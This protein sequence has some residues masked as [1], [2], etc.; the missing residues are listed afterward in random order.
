MFV[1]VLATLF[2][3]THGQPA[4][5]WADQPEKDK[6]ARHEQ[7]MEFD[8]E[9]TGC[10]GKFPCAGKDEENPTLAKLDEIMK[11]I[12][13]TK[14][15]NMEAGPEKDAQLKDLKEKMVQ[16]KEDLEKIKDEK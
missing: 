11:D 5:I 2:V 10:P 16:L 12:D 1:V 6:V 7:I 4:G 14:L 3:A 13:L 15:K 8:E 9:N